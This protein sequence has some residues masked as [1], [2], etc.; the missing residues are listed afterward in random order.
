MKKNKHCSIYNIGLYEYWL[1]KEATEGKILKSAG[2]F[3]GSVSE[4]EESNETNTRYRL[5]AK[6]GF[7]DFHDI[8]AT[9]KKY[10]WEHV[11][12][13]K[14][15]EIYSSTNEDSH[16]IDS[17][18]KHNFYHKEAIK[19]RQKRL[20]ISTVFTLL[21]LF[22]LILL[23]PFASV[24]RPFGFP[25][26]LIMILL[27]IISAVC[28]IRNIGFLS[29][30]RDKTP[31]YRELDWK[32][33]TDRTKVFEIFKTAFLILIIG[34]LLGSRY[35]KPAKNPLP[36]DRSAVPFATAV[37]FSADKELTL[38]QSA[39][40]RSYVKQWKTPLSP[41]NYDWF[42]ISGIKSGDGKEFS[43]VFEVSYHEI[44]NPILAKA[45]AKSYYIEDSV[46]SFNT[47]DKFEIA[48]LDFDYGEMY[49]AG[50]NDC[51]ILLQ[52]GNKVIKAS[53]T[54]YSE[55]AHISD[56]TMNQFAEIILNKIS[57]FSER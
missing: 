35:I 11:S 31:D 16:L 27:L 38:T 37:D 8:E 50:R 21:F 53:F 43:I 56:E 47:F 23:T 6:K 49:S 9:R 12:D 55:N 46:S 45:V 15:I 7:E 18:E 32:K 14:C 48:E 57:Y 30:D 22:L 40:T 19:S 54:E 26:M 4:F 2:T 10:G 41:Q 44:I 5:W 51:I 24:N 42:E 3:K 39:E 13:E 34:I 33:L 20:I 29:I 1:N 28:N 25:S 36:D 52:K 17:D